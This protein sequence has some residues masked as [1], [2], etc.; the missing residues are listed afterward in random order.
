MCCTIRLFRK[1][2]IKLELGIRCYALISVARNMALFFYIAIA[3]AQKICIAW[4]PAVYSASFKN[5]NWLAKTG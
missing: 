5:L 4:Q 1:L 2:E 3:E